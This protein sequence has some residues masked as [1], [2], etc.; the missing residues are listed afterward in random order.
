MPRLYKFVYEI[1]DANLMISVVDGTLVMILFGVMQDIVACHRPGVI[2]SA[3]LL[4]QTLL[5][6]VHQ[7][8]N[9]CI[10]LLA[11]ITDLAAVHRL[12]FH[13]VADLRLVPMEAVRGDAAQ[14]GV[15]PPVVEIPVHPDLAREDWD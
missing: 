5:G 12:W 2:L 8:N 7:V 6:A 1:S 14:N 11:I 9:C 4:Y 10:P 13:G 3:Y 15:A